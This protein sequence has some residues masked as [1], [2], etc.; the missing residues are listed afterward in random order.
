VA[1]RRTQIYLDPEL[2]SSL[3]RLAE[4]RKTSRA[5]IIREAARRFV[6]IEDEGYGSILGLAGLGH[7][8]PGDVSERHDEYLAEIKLKKS[9][10]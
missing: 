4:Q 3:D 2:A 10:A 5:E 6:R 8:G 9:E 7:G 1:M